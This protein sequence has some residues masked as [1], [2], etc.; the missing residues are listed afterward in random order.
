MS[1][2]YFWLKFEAASSHENHVPPKFDILKKA[3]NLGLVQ[4]QSLSVYVK[5]YFFC[6]GSFIFSVFTYLH[7]AKHAI[8]KLP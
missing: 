5:S 3:Y 7:N 4:R 6:T 8:L 2:I 1:V